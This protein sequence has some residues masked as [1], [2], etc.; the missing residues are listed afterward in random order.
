MNSTDWAREQGLPDAEEIS[1]L[2]G[3]GRTAAQW[4]LRQCRAGKIDRKQLVESRR[5]AH[6][7]T[8]AAIREAKRFG[9]YGGNAEWRALSN[10]RKHEGY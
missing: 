4:R 9:G 10:R 6:K 8:E 5:E 3:I 2:A 1:R 7:R